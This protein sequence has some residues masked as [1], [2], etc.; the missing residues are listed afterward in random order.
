MVALAVAGPPKLPPLPGQS[1]PEPAPSEPSTP[2]KPSTPAKPSTPG[3]PTP[4]ATPGQ[5]TSK[6]PAAATVA[7]AVAPAATPPETTTPT[8]RSEPTIAPPP[9]PEPG[10]GGGIPET[11]AEPPQPTPTAPPPKPV[12]EG[13]GAAPA[14]DGRLP[15][16]ETDDAR[17]RMPPPLRP[18]Y[19]G[20]GLFIGAGVTFAVALSEQIAGHVLVKRR[21]IDP[22]AKSSMMLDDTDDAEALG[23][24]IVRCLPGVVPAVALRVNSDI[25]LLATIGMTAAGAMLRAERKAYD[26]AFSDRKQRNIVALRGAGVGLIAAGVIT[27]FTLGPSAWAILSKCDTAKCA[28]RARVMAF[29]TRD[30]G[31]AM[32]AAGAG[33]LGFSEA[34]RRK[35]EGFARE[36]AIMFAPQLGR[37][38]AGLGMSGKF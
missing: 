6:L 34:Y 26:D 7:P 10:N 8:P 36:R 27:W 31:A 18:P 22:V 38:M 1:A 28:G 9:G 15:S 19:K 12:R 17:P 35:H 32:A 20:I 25:A 2:T 4:K 13:P 5:P 33:M 3:K 37:G 23:D 30:I 14:M 24:A 29:T 16:N 11:K 21:C